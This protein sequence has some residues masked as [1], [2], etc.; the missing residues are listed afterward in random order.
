MLPTFVG[1][2]KDPGDTTTT[3]A[4]TDAWCC[5]CCCCCCCCNNNNNHT[6]SNAPPQRTAN[7][8]QCVSLE[9]ATAKKGRPPALTRRRRR[10]DI[11]FLAVARA[12][13]GVVVA[14][15]T[16]QRGE[17]QEQYH[18]AVRDVLSAKDFADQVQAGSRYRLVGMGTGSVALNTFNFTV[19]AEKRVYICVAQQSYPER[20][21][22]LLVNDLVQRFREEFASTSLNCVS[23]ALDGRAKRMFNQLVE[24]FD[25]PTKLDKLA[26]VQAQ[27]AGAKAAVT[28]TIDRAL[29]NVDRA[30]DIE[31]KTQRL[32]EA[33]NQFHYDSRRL[34]WRE[35]MRKYRATACLVLAVLLLVFIL[36]LAFSP[37]IP[38]GMSPTP[39]GNQPTFSPVVPTPP[40][41]PSP[42]GP[43]RPPN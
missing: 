23:G 2:W 34:Q 24:Q 30:K 8:R 7:I 16:V 4:E 38:K 39:A 22:F 43:T 25:D 18:A 1:T 13:D 40:T 10:K 33:A 12:S 15:L 28:K 9:H 27:V 32:Q 20:L 42:T 19:D 29:S 21:V 6:T 26:Q 5:C 11:K 14:S 35:R 17:S 3:L 31:D 41:T 36:V 37:L